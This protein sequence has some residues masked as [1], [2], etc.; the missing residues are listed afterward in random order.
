MAA[1][2]I[3][4]ALSGRAQQTWP[5]WADMVGLAAGVK[6]PSRPTPV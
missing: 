4:R 3:D 5:R 6:D 1:L 2:V